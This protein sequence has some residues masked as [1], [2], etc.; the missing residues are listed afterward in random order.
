M[1]IWLVK[2]GLVSLITMKRY[3]A[4]APPDVRD[5]GPK[6]VH[7]RILWYEWV[8]CDAWEASQEI[9]L[10][11]RMSR[12]ISPAWWLLYLW[13]DGADGSMVIITY[14]GRW[15]WKLR[16][17]GRRWGR[18]QHYIRIRMSKIALE[19]DINKNTVDYI[20]NYDVSEREPVVLPARFL[21]CL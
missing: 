20:D 11:H 16:F 21:T 6:P 5:F 1:L 9:S 2:W 4:R 18:C 3:R 17:Y 15:P 14:A 7:R 8:G 12:G 13:S 19:P 10:H